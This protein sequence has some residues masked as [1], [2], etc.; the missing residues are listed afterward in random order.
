M[1]TLAVQSGQ[2]STSVNT[3]QTSSAGAP[4]SRVRLKWVWMITS[5]FYLRGMVSLEL[6]WR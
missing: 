4:I 5:E 1:E 3:V 2:R 6:P